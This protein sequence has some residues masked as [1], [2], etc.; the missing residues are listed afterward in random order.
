M[1][2]RGIILA[3]GRGSRMGENTALKPKCLTVLH[4]KTL[5]DWQLESLHK[6]GV[7]TVTVVRGYRSEMLTGDFDVVNNERWSETNMV[8]S[9]FCVED[10]VSDSIISYSDIVYK[11]EHITQLKQAAGDIVITADLSWKALWELRFENPLDDAETF[12]SEEDTL[13]EIGNKTDDIS[14]IQAQYMGLLKFSPEGWKVLK[15][16]YETFPAEKKDNMHMTGM[17]NELLKKNI[18]VKVVFIDGGWCEADEW[19]DIVAYENALKTNVNWKHNW[20]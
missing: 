2:H 12:K 7:E 9:L 18:E 19:S 15:D 3:A 14:E 4:G 8:A 20:R 13:L 6:G 16:L 1:K 17:L 10:P 5:L 11:P